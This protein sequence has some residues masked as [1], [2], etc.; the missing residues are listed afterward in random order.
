MNISIISAEEHISS[1][2]IAMSEGGKNYRLLILSTKA[3]GVIDGSLCQKVRELELKPTP[4]FLALVA[5][6]YDFIDTDSF[7]E[8]FDG[9]IDTRNDISQTLETITHV[10]DIEGKY[11]LPA[12][13]FSGLRILLVEDNYI[14]Q[15]VAKA[16]LEHFQPIVDIAENGLI[17]L[18]KVKSNAYDL[19]LMDMQMPVMDGLTATRE[20]RKLSEHVQLPII[21]MTANVLKQEIEECLTAGMNDHIAKPIEVD[22]LIFAINKWIHSEITTS[23]SDDSTAFIPVPKSN[24][25]LLDTHEGIQ[26]LGGN[27]STYWSLVKIMLDTNISKLNKWL[28]HADD[29][30]VEEAELFGHTLRGSAANVSAKSLSLLASEL[31]KKAKAGVSDQG[32]MREML[33]VMHEIR[34]QFMHIDSEARSQESFH[35]YTTK[36]LRIELEQLQILLSQFDSQALEFIEGIKQSANSMSIDLASIHS[37]IQQFEYDAAGKKVFEVIAE[38]H[39]RE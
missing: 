6:N 5:D 27:E 38:L 11:Q 13:D 12:A 34:M 24:I 22:E 39:D 23:E 3:E 31:E 7:T 2:L 25:S 18:D 37:D 32:V 17:A 26:R 36:E 29:I 28:D 19:V 9:I 4:I 14:N 35:G 16:L 1:E 8:H 20:I 33:D 15:E 21:A 30:T 10:L